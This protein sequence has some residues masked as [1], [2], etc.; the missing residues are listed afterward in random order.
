MKKNLFE[1]F[2]NLEKEWDYSRNNV[3]PNNIGISSNKKYWWICPKGHSYETSLQVRT[4]KN[5]TGCPYCAGQKVLVGFNDLKTRFPE[6][7]KEWDYE[8]NYPLRPEN[9]MPGSSK[10]AW[11]ICPNGHSYYSVISNRRTGTGCAICKNKKV[12]KGYNDL[13][14]TRPDLLELWNYEKNNKLGIFPTEVTSISGKKVW[15]ICE[16]GDEWENT[17]AHIAY[18]ERCPYCNERKNAGLS[19]SFPE[20]AIYYYMKQIDNSCINRYKYKKKY[21]I[22]VFIKDKKIGI[23]Y[24]GYKWHSSEVKLTREKNKNIALEEGGIKL[25]RVKEIDKKEKIVDKYYKDNNIFFLNND[26]IINLNK[27]IKELIRI[28]FN[29]EIKVDIEEDRQNIYNLY[30]SESQ[31]DSVLINKELMKWWDYDKNLDIKPENFTRA[32][33]RIVWWKCEKGH[34]FKKS[35]HLMSRRMVCPECF[36]KRG[37]DKRFE[38]KYPELLKEWDYDMNIDISPE[39]IQSGNHHKIWWKCEKGHSWQAQIRNRIIGCGCPYC[40]NK[41]LLKGFNDL[42]TKYPEVAKEWNYNKNIHLGITLS[43]V[44]YGSHKRVWWKCSKCGFEWETTISS[45][46]KNKTGCR[47]CGRIRSDKRHY[48]LSQN[49]FLINNVI[50]SEYNY[51][52]NKEIDPSLI[53]IGSKKNICWKCSKC[54]FEYES[55]P[56]N[57]TKGITKCK[58]CMKENKSK[59]RHNFE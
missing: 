21:E 4:R 22:D 35:V 30:L 44:M 43:D 1:L 10:K 27:I 50:M 8:K 24:D 36:K 56:Y 9:I 32:S 47:V 11:W 49:R 25:Y 48:S 39:D 42:K 16:H 53:R 17:I 38:L 29:K 26:D 46:T 20:Q 3:D 58:N 34:S 13:A 19:T 6:V 41:K 40:S 14:T 7:A 15:W 59:T 45:R 57:M 54:G 23:E 5:S 31:K 51:E 33:G 52:R 2:P 18:G 37:Y 28:I 55:T 12:L